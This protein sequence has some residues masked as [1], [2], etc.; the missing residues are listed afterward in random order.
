MT[1]RD[2]RFFHAL[3][4]DPGDDALRPTYADFLEEYGNAQRPPAPNSS[5][6]GSSWQ[7]SHHSAA[8]RPS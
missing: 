3:Q 4:P 1:F 2:D 8:A 6:C 7:R 5:A